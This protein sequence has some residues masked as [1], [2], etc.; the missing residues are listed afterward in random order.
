MPMITEGEETISSHANSLVSSQSYIS[1]HHDNIPTRSSSKE[2]ELVLVDSSEVQSLG[3]GKPW[4]EELA[5][6]YQHVFEAVG[7]ITATVNSKACSSRLM[8]IC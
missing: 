5:E 8:S 6:M 3:K 1:H 4:Q 7:H 2:D